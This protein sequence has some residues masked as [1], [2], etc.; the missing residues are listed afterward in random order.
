MKPTPD[1]TW[2]DV[3]AALRPL[4]RADNRTNLAY[5]AAEYAWLA[6]VLCAC[7]AGF[8]AWWRGQVT[9]VAYVPLA[10][11]GVAVVAVSQHRL[12]GLA[13]E[14][15]HYT[16]LRGKLANELVSDLFLMFP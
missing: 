14:A 8:Q 15:S 7:S 12:S 2:D 4:L 16:L 6:V 5:L 1:L 13:H 9:T 11:I 3:Q 10:A